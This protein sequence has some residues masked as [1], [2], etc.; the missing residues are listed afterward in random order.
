MGFY[1]DYKWSKEQLV[2]PVANS[3][4]EDISVLGI[5]FLN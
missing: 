5:I 1:E 2:L 4:P 3:F